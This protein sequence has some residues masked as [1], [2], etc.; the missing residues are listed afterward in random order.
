MKTLYC[1]IEP[2]LGSMLMLPQSSINY[3]AIFI[4]AMLIISMKNGFPQTMNHG[5][6]WSHQTIKKLWAVNLVSS[7]KHLTEGYVY[8]LPASHCTSEPGSCCNHPQDT[9]WSD[10]PLDPH[11][12]LCDDHA[13]VVPSCSYLVCQLGG[14][15]TYHT[16]GRMVGILKNPV[17]Q[18][19]RTGSG[20]TYLSQLVCSSLTNFQTL[21][22]NL[23]SR[24]LFGN[25]NLS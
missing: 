22:L 5:F 15:R 14:W 1:P 2:L 9:A 19:N 11:A 16:W 21:L 23:T 3:I 7:N 6:Y 20:S 25:G 8:I 10:R 12:R 4:L 17:W 13:R 24:Q 18:A